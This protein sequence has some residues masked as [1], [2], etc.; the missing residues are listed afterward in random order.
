M[1]RNG[2]GHCHV[3]IKS[4]LDQ[5]S[6]RPGWRCARRKDFCM[7]QTTWKENAYRGSNMYLRQSRAAE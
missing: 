2:Y 7:R 3:Q 5:V 6:V 4:V 1:W